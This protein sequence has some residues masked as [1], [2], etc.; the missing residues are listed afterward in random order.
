VAAGGARAAVCFGRGRR[1]RFAAKQSKP[2][3]LGGAPEEKKKDGREK[4]ARDSP[5]ASESTG[6]TR[7]RGRLRRWIPSA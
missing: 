3:A 5:V 7:R 1:R 6:N 2:G 4:K